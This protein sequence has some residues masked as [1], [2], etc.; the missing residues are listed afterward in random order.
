MTLIAG[1]FGMN[2]DDTPFAHH[3]S[4]FWVILLLMV[5]AGSCFFAFVRFK[6]WL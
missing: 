3:A 6:K 1:V 5:A 2:V 4:G